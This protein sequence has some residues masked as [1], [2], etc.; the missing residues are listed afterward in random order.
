LEAFLDGLLGSLQPHLIFTLVLSSF[1][2]AIVGALPGLTATMAVALLVPF[3]FALSPTT[4]LVAIVGLMQGALYGD[5]V[6]ACLINTPGT[7]SAIATTFDGFPLT[8]QGKGQFALVASGVSS[9]GG[10]L[11]GGLALLFVSPPLAEFSLR[12]GPPEFFWIGIFGLTMIASLS[13][14][15]M[16]KGLAGGA[17]GMLVSTVGIAPAG[18]VPRF[19]F[20][21]P[22][23]QAGVNVV[24][25]LVGL[26]A[27]PQ[28]LKMVEE[29][30]GRVQLAEYE[31]HR[32][33]L[34]E[35]L[36]RVILRPLVLI[37]ST[38]I[39]VF[40]GILP[41]AG[42][43]IA[44][45]VS[46]S[47]A[48]RWSKNPEE[49]GKGSVDG[50]IAAESANNSAATA[51]LIPLLTLGIPG[52]PPAAIALGALLIHGLRPGQD[53]FEFSGDIVYTFMWSA[54][55][56]GFVI[57]AFSV[58]VSKYLTRVAT[59]PV[60]YLAPAVML[61]SII[62]S[63]AIRNNVLDVA[64]MIIIG[65]VGYALD[66][67][68]FKAGPIV[69]GL[70]LGPIVEAAFVSS[71]ALADARGSYLHVFFLRPLTM[72]IIVL[73]LLSAAWPWIGKRLARRA[74][75]TMEAL[76]DEG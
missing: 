14:G 21:N 12:F 5:S 2:G 36:E 66:K 1:V 38:L 16:F 53:L 20:G 15:S 50:V 55:W 9:A 33:V 60:H 46:Y 59:L 42:G 11:V 24:V 32:G 72:V 3:T 54:V 69:L 49:F 51:S 47:E 34:R 74:G 52:S 65:L 68:G 37:R 22:S 7:P 70:I 44:S 31:E 75:V 10:A 18:A 56:A 13:T 35:V 58:M 4:G 23:L 61:L 71:L 67:L 40:V 28:A 57:L 19:T 25:A 30:R 63:F 48:I 39:G 41:A 62:G 73:T 17:L 45:L 29:I 76:D 8:Q 27:V 43:P 64:M 26:F 6:P